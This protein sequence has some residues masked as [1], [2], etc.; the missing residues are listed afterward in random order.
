MFTIPTTDIKIYTHLTI[1]MPVVQLRALKLH[2]PDCLLPVKRKLLTHWL[3]LIH[4]EF[5]LKLQ[6]KF[7]HLRLTHL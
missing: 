1:H 5:N 6:C 2:Q 3:P 7:L 4:S